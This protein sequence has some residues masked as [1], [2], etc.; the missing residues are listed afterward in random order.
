MTETAHD[1]TTVGVSREADRML[2]ALCDTPLFEREVDVYRLA[3]A[4]ALAEDLPPLPA[5]SKETKF[6]VG[7][8]DTPTGQVAALVRALANEGT[9][10]PYATSQGYAEAGIRHLYVQFVERN[11]SLHEVFDLKTTQI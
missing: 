3:V 8:L 9:D 2:K 6:N 1:V 5:S 11:S 10:R 4:V 7:T